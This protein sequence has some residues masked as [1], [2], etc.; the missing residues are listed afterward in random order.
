MLTAELRKIVVFD[1]QFAQSID[2]LVSSKTMDEFLS[3]SRDCAQV[4]NNIAQSYGTSVY[5]QYMKIYT[6]VK[7]V[8]LD[9]VMTELKRA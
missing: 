5:E 6:E 4:L 9:G 2:K 1:R 3:K 8:A 7:E